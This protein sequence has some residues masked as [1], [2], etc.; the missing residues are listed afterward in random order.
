MPRAIVGVAAWSKQLE[1]DQ[2]CRLLGRS[3]GLGGT[4]TCVVSSEHTAFC[5]QIFTAASSRAAGERDSRF[6]PSLR[7]AGDLRIDNRGEF[8]ARCGLS[9]EATAGL[10]DVELVAAGWSRCGERIFEALVGPYALAI[11]CDQRRR[12]VL[13]R[14]PQGLRPLFYSCHQEWAAFASLPMA[15]AGLPEI[16]RHLNRQRLLDILLLV[17]PQGNP[18]F[19]DG[20]EAVRKGE[21]VCL[22]GPGQIHRRQFWH[23]RNIAVERRRSPDEYAEGLRDRLAQ[24]VH[25]AVDTPQKIATALSGGFDSGVVSGLAADRL[26]ADGRNLLAYTAIPAAGDVP[27]TSPRWLDSEA[28]LAAEVAG[29]HPN[30]RHQCIAPRESS[31]MPLFDFFFE[32]VGAPCLSPVVFQWYGDIEQQAVSDG[33]KVMLRAT[34]GNWTISYHG[35]PFLLHLAEQRHWFRLLGWLLRLR[36]GHPAA[37]RGTV[38]RT[39]L[40]KQLGEARWEALRRMAGKSPTPSWTAAAPAWSPVAPDRFPEFLATMDR[41]SPRFEIL[42]GGF[43]PA[44]DRVDWLMRETQLPLYEKAVWLRRGLD[45]RDP[46]LDRRVVEF[47]LSIPEEEF[48]RGGLARAVF[49]RAFAG[50]L[51]SAVLGNDRI[52]R[53]GYGREAGL[54]RSLPGFRDEIARIPEVSPTRG[55]FDLAALERLAAVSP[56]DDDG[57]NAFDVAYMRKLSRGISAL[58]FV[59]RM[60]SGN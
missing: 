12:L 22:E 60:G 30:I 20:I 28:A 32:S 48:L 58:H 55:L 52:G 33:A 4:G 46:T 24:A 14:D 8:I 10:T 25:A 26:D 51:P 40:R 13:A 59:N 6:D 34:G 2:Y 42:Q 18:S 54:R 35:V 21:M 41:A 27:S 17:D 31:W 1:L 36:G 37:Q 44:S 47:C 19:F 38:L 23:A 5:G 7:V 39:I 3:L 9:A 57:S 50:D 15:L 43:G 53:Q 45:I 49:R 29:R 11:W 16:G 56:E